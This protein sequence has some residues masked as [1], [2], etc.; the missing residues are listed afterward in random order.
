MADLFNAQYHIWS[1]EPSEC[2]YRDKSES[3]APLGVPQRK[4]ANKNL[5][6]W[7]VIISHWS[8]D[9]GEKKKN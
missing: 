4:Q 8:M 2:E 6:V 1:L 9:N 3:W 5:L 7:G